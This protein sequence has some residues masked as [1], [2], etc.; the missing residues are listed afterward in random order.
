[1]F[2]GLLGSGGAYQICP[3][4]RS[5]AGGYYED[6]N[7]I[8]NNRWI[9]ENGAVQSREALVYPGDARRAVLLRQ[10]RALAG[11]HLV[12]VVLQPSTDYGR[13]AAGRWSKDGISQR[14]LRG[15]IPGLSSTL[16]S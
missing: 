3:K 10:V 8:W 14:Q 12:K 4:G 7:L 9:T 2:A 5:V 16:C 1:M 11:S 13:A 6:G 15:N